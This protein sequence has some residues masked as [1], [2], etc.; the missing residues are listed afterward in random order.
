MWDYPGL[1]EW[2]T[3]IQS[4]IFCVSYCI[5]LYRGV[6]AFDLFINKYKVMWLLCIAL[7]CLNV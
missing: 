4:V 2:I 5:F 1:S 7:L 3:S 6:I